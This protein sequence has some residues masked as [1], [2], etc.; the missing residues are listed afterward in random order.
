MKQLKETVII[1]TSIVLFLIVLSASLKELANEK[2][3]KEYRTIK[4]FDSS[5]N[6]NF[7]L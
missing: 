6:D 3:S 1:L 2:K 5:E 7:K 4:Q